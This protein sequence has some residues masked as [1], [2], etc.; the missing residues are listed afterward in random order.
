MFGLDFQLFQMINSLAG[1]SAL[2]DSLGIF[3]ADYLKY[4]LF[5][6]FGV[7]ILYSF[8]K[9]GRKVDTAFC[10]LFV[11]AVAAFSYFLITPALKD[12]F[13]RPRP[14]VV[15]Q[16]NQLI[17]EDALSYSFPSG[18]AVLTFALATAILFFN[19]KMGFVF[20]VLAFFTSFAQVFVGVHYPFDVIGGM[21]VGVVF[22][23]ISWQIFRIPGLD[24]TRSL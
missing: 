13:V 23:L 24:I 4:L 16:V 3:C 17:S 2:I 11:A 20:L 14:F 8:L 12:L 7:F 15:H 21:L 6:A 1:K 18:S 5:L 9:K 22:S 10:F 19:R